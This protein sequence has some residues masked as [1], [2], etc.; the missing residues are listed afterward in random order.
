MNECFIGQIIL[1]PFDFAPLGFVP[2]DGQLM[3]ISS[4]CA[5]FSLIG[6]TFGGDGQTTFAVPN[7]KDKAPAGVH[8]I[9][10]TEGIYPSRDF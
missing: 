1:V 6:T 4:N 3:P 2:C 9:M 8:Y 7:L 5:L 10:A